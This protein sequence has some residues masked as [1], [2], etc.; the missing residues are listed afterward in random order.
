MEEVGGGETT[1]SPGH[2]MADQVICAN[3]TP[4]GAGI[5]VSNKN[6]LKTPFI[7]TC[8]YITRSG[9]KVGVNVSLC[10]RQCVV[11]RDRDRQPCV[12]VWHCVYHQ[13]ALSANMS[14]LPLVTDNSHLLRCALSF[15]V[16]CPSHHMWQ[17]GTVFNVNSW[18]SC[19][20]FAIIGTKKPWLIF[21]PTFFWC[22]E[23]TR[24]TSS[25]VPVP[26]AVRSGDHL[27]VR[28]PVIMLL[29]CVQAPQKH[30]WLHKE[31]KQRQSQ[32]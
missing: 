28:S 14:L 5:K 25:Q 8:L 2:K 13:V 10:W 11:L 19:F 7:P 24:I 27:A 3:L 6:V 21:W 26:R 4:H 22:I 31:Q 15:L 32:F 20:F 16:P 29:F 23:N 9:L 17:A 12:Q 1:C 18:D 30:P